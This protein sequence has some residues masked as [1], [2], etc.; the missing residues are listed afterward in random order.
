MI[1]PT[2][3]GGQTWFMSSNPNTDP[4]FDP[5][6]TMTQNGDGSWRLNVTAA[7][8]GVYTTDGYTLTAGSEQN[9]LILQ[10]RQY[11]QT[12]NDW[13]NVE[14]TGFVRANSVVAGGSP[15]FT[16]YARG[17]KHTATRECEGSSYKCSI[18]P[19]GNIR[20]Q[21]ESWHVYY[22]QQSYQN[23]G[24]SSTY[25]G[26]FIG[27]KAIIRNVGTSKVHF[28]AYLNDNA[29][30]TTW[31]SVDT[32]EDAGTWGGNATHCGGTNDKMIMLWGGPSADF[33]WDDQP[34][35]DCKWLSVREIDSL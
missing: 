4:R 23:S 35:V 15:H 25:V 12:V 11:M 2:K 3:S 10:S 22:D 13:K 29:D 17:G 5:Q 16:W 7:R 31:V 33:R 26:R 18:Y 32:F 1:Y 21:K 19:N 30:K 34:S 8:M 20:W 9:R 28:E 24:L 6:G 14:I 27:F